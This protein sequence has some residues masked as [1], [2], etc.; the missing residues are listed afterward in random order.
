MQGETHQRVKLIGE[1]KKKPNAFH[2]LDSF[3]AAAMVFKAGEVE[4]AIAL[5]EQQDVLDVALDM[6]PLEMM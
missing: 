3:R 2:I 1:R 6:K 4:D 5:E